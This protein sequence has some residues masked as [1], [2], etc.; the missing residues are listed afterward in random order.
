MK[1]LLL[2]GCETSWSGGLVDRVETCAWCNSMR[3]GAVLAVMT[4]EGREAEAGRDASKLQVLQ[5]AMFRSF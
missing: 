2:C 5:N 3:Y 1:E 4:R